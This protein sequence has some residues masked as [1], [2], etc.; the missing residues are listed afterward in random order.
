MGL[1]VS[2]ASH[3]YKWLVIITQRYHERNDDFYIYITRFAG[4]TARTLLVC[5][6]Y[7]GDDGNDGCGGWVCA[8]SGGLIPYRISADGFRAAPFRAAPH[9][10]FAS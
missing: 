8:I 7:K 4:F 2:A 6:Y 1:K 9:P 5:A 3:C 10:D